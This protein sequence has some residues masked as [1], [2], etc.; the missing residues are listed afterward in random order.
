MLWAG[1]EPIKTSSFHPGNQHNLLLA[2]DP[3]LGCSFWKFQYPR[4]TI[5]LKFSGTGSDATNCP[6]WSFTTADALPITV[7]PYLQSFEAGA[8]GW[9]S[10][11]VTGNNH[12]QLGSPAQTQIN[13]SYGGA[14]AW[15]TYLD[16]NYENNANTWL[17]SPPFNFSSLNAPNFSVWL[18]I[19]C[20][21][22]YDVMILESSVDAGASWQY[23]SGDDCFYINNLAYAPISVPKWSGMIGNWV[24]YSS[25]LAGLENQALVHLRF[26]FASDISVFSEGIAVD[27]VRIWNME[28]PPAIAHTPI[29]ADNATGVSID[30]QLGWT[31]TTTPGQSDPVAYAVRGG[32]DPLLNTYDVAHLNGGPGTYSIPAFFDISY[33]G[34]YYWQVI[35]T[36]DSY[37]V[38]N[39]SQLAS[40]KSAS[41]D[42]R[43][44]AQNCPIWSFTVE[45]AP[46]HISA[47]PYI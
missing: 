26:R 47:F 14:N 32:A 6:I 15:M 31:Y 33:G 20:E 9:S 12:W 36:T 29:P 35:P 5:G 8:A 42:F 1:L 39:P 22:G 16:A 46:V 44:D 28:I 18:N 40:S 38:F 4:S 41:Q 34:T 13:H 25:S 23:V 10:G 2:G 45:A 21:S 37:T 43:S 19:Y 11:A 30:T 27:D 7:F 3:D 24:Q 17:K